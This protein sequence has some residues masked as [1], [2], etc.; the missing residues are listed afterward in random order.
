MGVET[1]SRQDLT[2]DEGNVQLR[3][4]LTKAY[5]EPTPKLCTALAATGPDFQPG[6][7]QTR[8]VRKEERMGWSARAAQSF[9]RLISESGLAGREKDGGKEGVGRRLRRVFLDSDS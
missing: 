2:S 9:A 5:E 6:R 7:G 1:V 4:F 8:R 3:T